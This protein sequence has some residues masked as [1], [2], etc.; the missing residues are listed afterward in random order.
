M[1]RSTVAVTLSLCALALSLLSPSL[2][3]ARSLI[4]SSPSIFDN[5]DWMDRNSLSMAVTNHGSLAFDLTTGQGGLEYPRGTG[6]IAV[7]AAGIWVGA[8]VAG[9]VRA[10]VGEYIQEYAPGPMSGGTFLPDQ[11]QFQNYRIES[12]GTGY[13]EYMND[14][15]PQGAPLDSLGNPLLLGDALI[16][17]VFNDAN[18]AWHVNPAGS[19][20]PLGLEIQQSVFAFASGGALG[21]TVFV[22]WRLANKGANR[23]D[24]A[25]VSF[26]ADPDLG[27]PADD[28]VGCDTTM[29]L[30]YAY[31]G[32]NVDAIYGSEPPTVGFQFLRGVKVDG[33][34]LGMTSFMKYINGSDPQDALQTYRY[35]QGRHADG[36]P[37]FV[38]DDPFQPVTT[39]D[40]PGDPVTSTGC[41]DTFADDRRLTLS[42]GPF[43]MQPGDTQV[44]VMAIEVGQ[45]INRLA[46]IQD[47][48]QTAATAKL[49]YNAW[50]PEPTTAVASYVVDSRAEPGTIH[51]AWYV[52]ASAGTPI[53]VERRTETTSWNAVAETTLPSD[54]MLRF[55]DTAIDPDERYG[56]RLVVWSG[57]LQDYSAETWIQAAAED[58][59]TTLRLLA[60]RPNPSAAS[61]QFRHYVPQRGAFRLSVLDVQGRVI[62]ILSDR[63]VMPGWQE[64]T[65]DGR[66]RSGREAASGIYFVRAEGMGAAETR[67]VVLSR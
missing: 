42:S 27:D 22:K 61:F 50:F 65:W 2:A 37:L 34:D 48:R 36:T 58:A 5:D 3:D 51:L 59:P 63:E 1:V 8:K 31:N 52:P 40:V 55:D 10:T 47:L 60:G 35:M 53:T 20:A 64:S 49:L 43:T 9:E 56:Y 62:R 38:C 39:Y 12:G 29:S 66:D 17:S 46:S 11:L 41:L 25:Y 67:K 24:S 30:G 32:S 15:V 28:L 19:T 57:A 18:P 6:R 54:G 21:K 16:W 14:A 26:W 44:V 33:V 23:L 7:Y 4:A 13:T 45:G